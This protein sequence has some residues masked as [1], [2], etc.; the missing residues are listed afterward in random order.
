MVVLVVMGVIVGSVVVVGVLVVGVG[1]YHASFRSI[2]LFTL[3][4]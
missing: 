3:K 2:Y 4:L 1:A